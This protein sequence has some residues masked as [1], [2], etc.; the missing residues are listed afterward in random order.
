[1]SALII[2]SA[3]VSIYCFECKLVLVGDNKCDV[4]GGLTELEWCFIIDI[5][6]VIKIQKKLTMSEFSK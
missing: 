6:F 2:I 3:D 4:S 5:L 1:M